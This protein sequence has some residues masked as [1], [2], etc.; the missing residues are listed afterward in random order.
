VRM[1]RS[2]AIGRM[3]D[4]GQAGPGGPTNWP[5]LNR[6]EDPS[7]PEPA[8]VC[9]PRTEDSPW[10]KEAQQRK[11]GSVLMVDPRAASLASSAL[12]GLAAG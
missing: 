11:G 12:R 1:P 5:R 8:L 6:F 7:A 3:G 9:W 2:P 10:E 4:A